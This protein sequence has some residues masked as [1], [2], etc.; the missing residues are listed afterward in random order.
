MWPAIPLILLLQHSS[1]LDTCKYLLGPTYSY[2]V[3]V[4]YVH[5]LIANVRA[6]SRKSGQI[7]VSE[8][9]ANTVCLIIFVIPVVCGMNFNSGKPRQ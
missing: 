2:S 3:I 7:S 6:K 8:V 5:G 1:A 9:F 4:G